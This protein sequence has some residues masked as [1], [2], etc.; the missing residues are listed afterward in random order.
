MPRF[1]RY[2]VGRGEYL[3]TRRS[4]IHFGGDIKD[5]VLETVKPLLTEALIEVAKN[6]LKG[7]AHIANSG[8][9]YFKRKWGRHAEEPPKFQKMSDQTTS[10][11]IS[12]ML[13]LPAP[14]S[15][16]ST[17]SLQDFETY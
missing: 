5:E 1:R 4:N 16:P 11:A 6:G 14:P 12:P 13:A 17:S 2:H 10:E 9:N 7:A 3:P 8:I 15:T